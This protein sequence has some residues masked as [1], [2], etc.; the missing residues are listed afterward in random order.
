VATGI[1]H[2]LYITVSYAQYFTI[3]VI[4]TLSSCCNLLLA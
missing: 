1:N 4:I 2:M 3:T